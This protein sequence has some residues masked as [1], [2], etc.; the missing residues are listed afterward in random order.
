MAIG[1]GG[2]DP[3]FAISDLWAAL[4]RFVILLRGEPSFG[5][6]PLS[7]QETY[8]VQRA[9]DKIP[10]NIDFAAAELLE[11]LADLAPGHAGADRKGPN[12]PPPAGESGYWNPRGVR[13][14]HTIRGSASRAS[15]TVVRYNLN[16]R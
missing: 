10:E 8:A 5:P 4:A 11:A 2:V 14:R 6:H 7:R 3:A 9:A 16:L 13:T 1:L 15:R 12:E